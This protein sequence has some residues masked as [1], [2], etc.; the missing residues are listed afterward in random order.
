MKNK[1]AYATIILS[2]SGIS[3]MFAY[4]IGMVINFADTF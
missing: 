2:L 3:A 1:I 4:C